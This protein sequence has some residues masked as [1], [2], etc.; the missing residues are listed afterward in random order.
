LIVSDGPL[1]QL[2]FAALRDPVDP[3]GR[4]MGQVREVAYLPSAGA[5]LAMRRKRE[6]AEPRVAGVAVVADPVFRPDDPR[7]SSSASPRQ[8]PEPLQAATR[9]FGFKTIPRL[10]YSRIEGESVG[11][12]SRSP[13]LLFDFDATR[14]AFMTGRL[15][16]YRVVHFAAHGLSNLQDPDLSGLVL[17][18]VDRAGKPQNGF[19]RFQDVYDQ[20][21][22]SELVV[23]SACQTAI[24][25]SFAETGMM[26]LAGAFLHAGAASVLS[27]LWK[28]DDEATA[29]FM[30]IFYRE[31]LTRK[32]VPRTA[33]KTAQAELSQISRWKSPYYWGAF[34]LQGWPH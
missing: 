31:L 8:M 2:P 12:Y 32:V 17:S 28:I 14:D 30:K 29:E 26:T 25:K 16:D 1:Q 34:V 20:E 27:T 4:A 9:A 3:D 19:L 23:L 18:L 10:L 33:L 13:L 21:I 24:G 11:S 6:A 22:N 5:V 15:R 7:F